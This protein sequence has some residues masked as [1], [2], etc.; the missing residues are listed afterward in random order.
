MTLA[1]EEEHG[2]IPDGDAGLELP[3]A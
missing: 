2:R 1:R 3:G